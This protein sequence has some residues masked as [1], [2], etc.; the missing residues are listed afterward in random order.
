MET[1]SSDRGTTKD[2]GT[3]WELICSTWA[4]MSTWLISLFLKRY[5]DS[6][7]QSKVVVDLTKQIFTGQGISR[8]VRSE[9]GPHFYGYYR[10][11]AK[12]YRLIHVTSSLNYPKKHYYDLHTKASPKSRTRSEDSSWEP[13]NPG[14]E[15]SGDTRQ[16]PGNSKILRSLHTKRQRVAAQLVADPRVTYR[17]PDYRDRW[18]RFN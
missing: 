1:P 10:Q 13:E 2:L 6:R 15:A 14:M 5:A 11:F 7:A 18:V 9:D 12:E 17:G 4:I 16:D 8:T 3:Q